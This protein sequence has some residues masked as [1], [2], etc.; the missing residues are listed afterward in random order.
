MNKPLN[1]QGVL[2]VNKMKE[3]HMRINQLLN[4]HKKNKESGKDVKI[5]ALNVIN[6]SG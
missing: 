5:E 3:Y 6:L 2:D 4:A 1:M